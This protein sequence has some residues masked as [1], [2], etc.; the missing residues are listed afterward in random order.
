MIMDNVKKTKYKE[1]A[2][3]MCK[4]LGYKECR[5]FILVFS[6]FNNMRIDIVKKRI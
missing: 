4:D 6:D 1:I 2:L 5:Q 3:S